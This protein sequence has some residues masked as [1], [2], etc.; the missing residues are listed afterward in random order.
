MYYSSA[1]ETFLLPPTE[2]PRVV[3]LFRPETAFFLLTWLVVLGL[4][5]E[6]GF[7]DP[8]SLWH[9]RVG[10][11]ILDHGFMWTDPFTF[12]HEGRTWIPQ[13]WGAEVLMAQIHRTGGLDALLLAFATGIAALFTWVF[14]RMR[15]AGMNPLLAGVMTA[16]C[17]FPGAFHFFVRPHMFT[18]VLL[19]WTMACLVDFDRGKAT[20][21]RLVGLIPLYVVWTNLHGGVLGGVMTFGLAVAGWGLLF[22]L[23][24]D[25]PIR[26][27]RL[28]FLIAGIL[29]ACGLTPFVNPFGMEM[30]NT[31]ARIV[32]SP[33]LKEAVS[34][35][36]PLDLA[37]ATGLLTVGFGAFYLF[38]LAGTWPLRPRVTW[39]LPLVWLVLTVKGI[40]QGP[41]FVVTAALAIP[42]LWPHTAW[43]RLLRKYGDSLIVD[44]ATIPPL[45]WHGV[46]LPVLAV[47]AALGLQLGRVVVPVVGHGWARFSPAYVPVELTEPIRA[48]ARSIGPR[49]RI[50]NDA[51]LGGYLIY[52]LPEV[53][54]F[55]DD[56][57]ELYGESWT[58]DYVDAYWHHPERIDEW[59]DRYG[60]EMALVVTQ[61]EP[62]PM[63]RYL[64]ASPRWVEVGRTECAAL[65]R[66]VR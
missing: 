10:D 65:F 66:R 45:G 40:R 14:A 53:K 42:D 37:S 38:L 51:N 35:H 1:G 43:C 34:E 26:S 7:Y 2:T 59:A 44:P 17:L 49:A 22:L 19:A 8:G 21:W 54:I 50:F 23:R 16:A 15:R 6:R 63:D 13:Q 36:Q 61:A 29:V 5:R 46:V 24:Q 52:H 62:T 30:L 58:K 47:L 27:W 57:F 55:M 9:V 20:L 32:G 31:W 39:L 41:L 12:T 60:L 4:F 18:I 28:A 3:R 33:V 48:Y 11:R 56:R 25:S 64:S